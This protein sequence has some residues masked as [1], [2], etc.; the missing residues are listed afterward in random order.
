MINRRAGSLAV[1]KEVTPKDAFDP[2]VGAFWGDGEYP[3]HCRRNA[4]SYPPY[5]LITW[6]YGRLFVPLFSFFGT[7]RRMIDHNAPSGAKR[8]KIW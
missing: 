7:G 6:R 2:V 5:D 8:R 3:S 1:A 4:E